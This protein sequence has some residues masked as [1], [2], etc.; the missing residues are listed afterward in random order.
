MEVE[1]AEAA[2]EL[3]LEESAVYDIPV[4]ANRGEEGLV[5]G[6]TIEDDNT[7]AASED[8]VIK[9]IIREKSSN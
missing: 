6:V 2:V 4:A 5:V 7:S 1:A 3:Q 8:D 9:I